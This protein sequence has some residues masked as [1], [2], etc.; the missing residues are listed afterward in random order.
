MKMCK[1]NNLITAV[2]VMCII[3]NSAAC[4]ELKAV[5]PQE[6]ATTVAQEEQQAEVITTSASEETTTEAAVETVVEETTT[7][8]AVNQVVYEGI[9]MNSTLPGKEWMKT[10]DGIITEPKFVVFNDTTNKK[11]IVENGQKVEFEATDT[12]AIY[13]PKDRETYAGSLFADGAFLDNTME[14]NVRFYFDLSGS[15]K[16]GDEVEITDEFDI[17]GEHIDMYSTLIFK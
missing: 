17:D 4:G 15:I 3:A 5:T 2:A 10:F 9:D 11:V 6:E 7:E 12:L 16:P 1:R 13:C 8:A 14:E